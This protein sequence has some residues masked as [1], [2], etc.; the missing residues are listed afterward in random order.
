ML[1][2][3]S[4]SPDV[5]DDGLFGKLK[6]DSKASATHSP[7]MLRPHPAPVLVLIRG[8]WI[9]VLLWR[10]LD[11]LTQLDASKPAIRDHLDESHR[12]YGEFYDDYDIEFRG[13]R[14]SGNRF[15]SRARSK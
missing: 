1:R 15:R 11:D 6:S 4:G 9:C 13:G 7:Q 2:Q 5:L 8:R 12:L 14:K 3:G 10:T